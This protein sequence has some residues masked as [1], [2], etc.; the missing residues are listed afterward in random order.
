MFT[1]FFFFS[2]NVAQKAVRRCPTIERI[3]RN[4]QAVKINW[5]R[6]DRGSASRSASQRSAGKPDPPPLGAWGERQWLRSRF[7][8]RSNLVAQPVGKFRRIVDTST[9][10]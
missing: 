3:A 7:T 4:A 8:P 2:H 9:L 5:G 1:T 6:P 10:L